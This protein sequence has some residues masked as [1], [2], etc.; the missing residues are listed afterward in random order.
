MIGAPLREIVH[1][2]PVLTSAWAIE[3]V[4]PEHVSLVWRRV[5]PY[6]EKSI[7]RFH[8]EAEWPQDE[9]MAAALDGRI[10]LWIA[11]SYHRGQIEGVVVTRL[12]TSDKVP[13]KQLCELPLWGGENLSEWG[14]D[15]FALIR[16]WAEEQGA[17]YLVGYGRRGWKRMF[18][19][20]EW[21]E[22]DGGLPILVKPVKE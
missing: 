19:A 3:G 18:G 2:T 22:T 17:D 4:L 21:G 1:K 8:A 11:W 15:M 10:Q 5:W 6:L 13:G 9:T 7:A 16:G 12:F 20:I 14:A